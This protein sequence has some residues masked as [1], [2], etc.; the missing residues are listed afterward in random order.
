MFGLENSIRQL[1]QDACLESE[2]FEPSSSSISSSFPPDHPNAVS[3]TVPAVLIRPAS[4]ERH[5][6]NFDFNIKMPLVLIWRLLLIVILSH[7]AF[8]NK[9]VSQPSTNIPTTPTLQIA[10]IF[11]PTQSG[12]C[13]IQGIIRISHTN[14][15]SF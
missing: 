2:S 8:T 4:S 11:K 15:M 12:A 3:K 13:F 10:S 9:P 7:L 5:M 14:A 1:D 6:D